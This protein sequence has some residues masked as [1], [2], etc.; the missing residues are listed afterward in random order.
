MYM[1][2]GGSFEEAEAGGSVSEHAFLKEEQFI[3]LENN[4]INEQNAHTHTHKC[5]HD[6]NICSTSNAHMNIESTE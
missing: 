1:C 5:T 3:N 6:E 4:L 2:A